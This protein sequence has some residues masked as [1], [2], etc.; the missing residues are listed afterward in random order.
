MTL[1]NSVTP[2]NVLVADARYHGMFMG[3]RGVLHN[4]SREIVRW[5]NERRW[6]ICLTEFKER[7]RVPM[8]P[9]RYTEL[10]FLDEATALAAGHRPCAECQRERFNWFV[11][12]VSFAEGKARLSAAAIDGRLDGER[13]DGNTQRGHVVALDDIPEGAMFAIGNAAFLKMRNERFVE[14]TPTG[15][16]LARGPMAAKVEMLTPPFAATALRGGFEPI[17]HPSTIIQ[18]DS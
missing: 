1:Q 11:E 10:F 15:Y 17:F 8:T 16:E 13:R 14:W 18:L 2:F 7:A 6:I 4:A 12:A 3:N 5:R 9:G